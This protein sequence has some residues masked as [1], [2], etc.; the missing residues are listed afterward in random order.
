MK[1]SILLYALAACVSF[2]ADF[3]H[4]TVTSGLGYF[5][6]ATR[7]KNGDILAVIRGGAAHSV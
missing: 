7:L 6:V 1:L 3:P 4:Q 2:A 5:P